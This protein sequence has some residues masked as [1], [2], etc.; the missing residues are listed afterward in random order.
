MDRDLLGLNGP[1]HDSNETESPSAAAITAVAKFFT[2]GERDHDANVPRW[3]VLP[4]GKPASIDGQRRRALDE[5]KRWAK[6]RDVLKHAI[7]GERLRDAH[8][9]G[10]LE[11]V[12]VAQL[13]AAV[14]PAAELGSQHWRLLC[15]VLGA[16]VAFPGSPAVIASHGD[17]AA[18]CG[19]SARSVRRR[20]SELA[21]L[22]L[23]RLEPTF[24]RKAAVHE[25]RPNAV[26]P[27]A[28]LVAAALG[29]RVQA[30]ASVPRDRER[31]RP[32]PN[33]A[34]HP[35]RDSGSGS[36][37]RQPGSRLETRSPGDRTSTDQP[38]QSPDNRGAFRAA[39]VAVLPATA[40]ETRGVAP[41]AL[42]GRETDALAGLQAIASSDPRLNAD[43]DV[44]ELLQHVAARLALKNRG[45]R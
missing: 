28:E 19:L 16:L 5:K 10:E 17:L 34:K 22:E 6:T 3:S 26:V 12:T 2:R 33:L 38:G 35:V 9:H 21:K 30:P 41:E 36:G 43:P 11:R 39:P 15:C 1:T 8:A 7:T 42:D 45:G 37:S 4:G 32:W 20:L 31:A 25:R 14:P 40:A 13:A 23:V 27:C 29:A 44:A 24:L 18:C